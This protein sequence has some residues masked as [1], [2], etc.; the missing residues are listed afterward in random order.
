M[1]DWRLVK[2]RGQYSL[3]YGTPRRRIATGTNDRGRAEAIAGE[4]WRRLNAAPTDQVADLWQAYVKDRQ[5]TVVRTD[6]FDSL[7]KALGPRFGHRL[8]TA[9]TD[10]DCRDYYKIRKRDGMSDSTVKTELEFLRACLR[11]KYGASAPHVWLPPSSAPRE[12]YL[13]KAEARELLSHIEAPH[14]RLFV[15][16]AITTGARMSAI[17]ELKWDQADL[18]RGT[19]DYRPAGRHQT[20][21]R[22]TVVPLNE[23]V[24][25]ELKIAKEGGLSE[26]V[27][28]YAGKQVK[29]IKKAIRAAAARAGIPASPHVFRHTA[30]VWMAEANIPMQK[31][32]QYLGH[33]TTTVTERTYARYSPSFMRDASEALRF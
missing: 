23:E 16:L 22:R 28:E 27:I 7:W 17:L 29:S 30:G 19:I 11:H 24:L 13:T 8:G 2:H 31:I 15:W 9:I 10:Q 26:Y 21:K 18:R 1:S 20:N 25:A 12:R 3:A 5:Q 33:T 4:I 6:R 32:A 14:V